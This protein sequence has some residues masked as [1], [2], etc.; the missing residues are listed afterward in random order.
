MGS[1][2]APSRVACLSGP[3]WSP[4]ADGSSF[5]AHRLRSLAWEVSTMHHGCGYQQGQPCPTVIGRRDGDSGVPQDRM[6]GRCGVRMAVCCD[7]GRDQEYIHVYMRVCIYI[8]LC[9]RPSSTLTNVRSSF[10]LPS[11]YSAIPS[12]ESQIFLI[13]SFRVC[14]LCQSL[15]N[16]HTLSLYLSTSLSQAQIH[17]MF[18][19]IAV[20]AALAASALAAPVNVQERQLDAVGGLVGDVTGTVD[21]VVS[22]ASN[23]PSI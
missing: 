11:N 16:T 7:G 14:D 2:L 13:H 10:T 5:P 9:K 8:H 15:Q 21:S 3:W 1:P 19:N 22:I 6:G 4:P 18:V 17:K 20:I 23:S 12:F